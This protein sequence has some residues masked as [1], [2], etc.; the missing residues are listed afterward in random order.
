MSTSPWSVLEL[1]CC[2]L[3]S[4]IFALVVLCFTLPGLEIGYSKSGVFAEGRAAMLGESQTVRSPP[5]V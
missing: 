3:M 4:G 2:L 1:S 5:S